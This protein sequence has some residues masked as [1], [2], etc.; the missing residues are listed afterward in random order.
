M[1]APIAPVGLSLLIDP[2]ALTS[3]ATGVQTASFTRMLTEGLERANGQLI[4][5]DRM[6]RA[7]AM[8]EDI[9]VH[10][11]TFALEQARL[12]FELVNQVRTR[13]LESYQEI[14]RMQV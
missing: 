2:A 11:V 8:G 7:F 4:E 14:M 12:S 1:T 9:P 6:T 13:L 10:Q 5:A 3:P